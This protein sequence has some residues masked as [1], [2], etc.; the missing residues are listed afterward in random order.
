MARGMG[1]ERARRL[2]GLAVWEIELA[3]ETGLLRRLADR[4][5]DPVSVNA[6]LAD[7]ERFQRMLAAEHRCNATQAAARLGIS[8]QRFKILAA[9]LTPTTV[10]EIS[11]YG[12]RLVVRHYRAGD[13]DALA[14][15]ARADTELRAAARALARSA[16]ARK[17]A[18][19]RKTNAARAETARA[20]LR[21][22][23][24]GRGTDPGDVLAWAAAAMEVSGICPRPLRLLRSVSDSRVPPY[25]EL[26][27]QARLSRAEQENLLTVRLAAVAELVTQLLPP[28]Q[29]EC[30]LGVPVALVPGDLP[31]FGDHLFSPT[32]HELG[33]AP[34]PWLL[35]A[36]ADHELRQAVQAEERRATAEATRREKR[37]QAAINAAARAASR[38]S[39]ASVGELFGLPTDVI[40]SLRPASGRWSADYVASL[41][42]TSPPWVRSETAARTEAARRRRREETRAARKGERQDAWRRHWAEA[43][44]VPVSQVP[45]RIGRPTPRAIE[46]VRRA[47]PPWTRSGVTITESD[48]PCTAAPHCPPSPR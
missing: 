38:L 16:G 35:L 19:T 5:F 47:L 2:L 32:V 26:L 42:R 25:V 34:P 1:R 24:E 4:T 21:D 46:A 22:V 8:A 17:A 41:L 33:L 31:H 30:A 13:V 36:R 3:T 44:G 43:F 11:K 48:G 14:D 28:H 45:E 23:L 7:S 15:K 20:E 18:R 6:A 27:R 29:A 9:D 10:E 37:A 40:H 39:D 12:K